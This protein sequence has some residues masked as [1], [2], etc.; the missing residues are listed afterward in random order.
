MRAHP[1]PR[2]PASRRVRAR[3]SK[4]RASC[5]RSLPSSPLLHPPR[6]CNGCAAASTRQR[7]WRRLRRRRPFAFCT[8]SSWRG[9]T[10]PSTVYASPSSLTPSSTE[11][12]CSIYVAITRRPP[13]GTHAHC[14]RRSWSSRSTPN[15]PS[16]S[17]RRSPTAHCCG[18]SCRASLAGSGPSPR[19]QYGHCT[20]DVRTRTTRVGARGRY[21]WVTR[22]RHRRSRL[23]ERSPR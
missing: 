8:R 12:H 21:R 7:R 4:P 17:T 15:I 14:F 19:P 16:F 11:P 20:V 3:N 13:A 18:C 9:T 1:P 6:R 5:R 10:T 2:T 22:A 23:R